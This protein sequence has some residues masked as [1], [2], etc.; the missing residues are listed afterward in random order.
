MSDAVESTR[1]LRED[2]E[3]DLEWLRLMRLAVDEALEEHRRL[4]HSVVVVRNEKVVWLK[5]GEY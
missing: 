1:V 2:T 3:R 5:P 4:G